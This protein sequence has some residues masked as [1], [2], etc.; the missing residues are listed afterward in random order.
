MYRDYIGSKIKKVKSECSEREVNKKERETS[1]MLKQI[2]QP[3]SILFHCC[4]ILFFTKRL[5]TQVYFKL[6]IC[7]RL[8]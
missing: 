2:L 8:F 7:I 6:L 5:Y 1:L 4:S 3:M